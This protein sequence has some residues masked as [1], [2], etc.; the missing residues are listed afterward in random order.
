MRLLTEEW[1]IYSSRR[2]FIR[3]WLDSAPWR[4]PAG[5]D[6]CFMGATISPHKHCRRRTQPDSLWCKRHRE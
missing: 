1:R 3:Y 6:R 2:R 5:D 4:R